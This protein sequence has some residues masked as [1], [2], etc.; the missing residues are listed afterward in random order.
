MEG[1]QTAHGRSERLYASAE[2]ILERAMEAQDLRTALQ[3][4]RAAVDVMGE[5]RG[6]LELQGEITG[7]LESREVMVVVNGNVNVSQPVHRPA[8]ETPPI[9]LQ[10]DEYTSG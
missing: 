8:T 3:A 9:D 10:P 4:I 7:E 1:V 5:A 2:D 6:Y